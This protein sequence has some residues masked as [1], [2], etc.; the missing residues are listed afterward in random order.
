LSRSSGLTKTI[1]QGTV[2]GSRKRGR[3]RKKW[4]DNIKEWTDLNINE[5]RKTENREEWRKL[6]VTASQSAPTV[7][8][9]KG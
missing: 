9:T 8:Q 6:V 4:D 3:Q 2:Q 1:L 5:L 7:T